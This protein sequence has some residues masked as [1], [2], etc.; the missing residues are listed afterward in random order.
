ML[1]RVVV[2]VEDRSM[3][4]A[5]EKSIS[6]SDVQVKSC[7]R[8]QNPW[9]GLVRSCGD[10]VVVSESIV[11]RP[12]ESSIAVLNDLPEKPTIVIIHGRDSSEEHAQL[13]AS[14]ADLVLYSGISRAGITEAIGGIIESRRQLGLMDRFDL[15]GRVKPRIEDFVSESEEMQ[16]FMDEVRQIVPSNS[17]LLILGETGVGKEHLAKAIHA[18]G[19]RASG[20]FITVNTP[21]L[22]EQLLESELFGHEQGAFTGAVRS[23]RGAFELAHGGTIFL[24]E[25]GEMPLH[26]Q[27]KLLRILQDFE[28]RPVGSEKPIWVDVRVIAA[29]NRDLEKE[30]ALGNFRQ[31]LYY[32]LSVVTLTIPPLRHRKEDIPMMSNYFIDY[33]RN[34]VGRDIDEVDDAA[35]EALGAYDWPGNIRE[36]M[37]VLERAMI[38]CRTNKITLADLPGAFHQRSFLPHELCSSAHKVPASW[39]SKTLAEV[40]G[41]VLEQVERAYLEMV[42]KKTGGRVGKAAAMAGIHPRGLY[43]KMVRLGLKKEAFK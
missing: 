7:G 33:F 6:L 32:R 24:D 4:R 17:L 15:K 28:V 36:L 23:R 14:G 26:L 27:A 11:P 43:D 39:E 9:Q 18:G 20:P 35:M 38:L 42:L 34:R 2:A 3:Q 22:P 5:L 21:A 37:N 13:V 10:V 16:M 1:I 40:R 19:P 29:T 25:I 31:D 41:E 12:L 30:A 8:L